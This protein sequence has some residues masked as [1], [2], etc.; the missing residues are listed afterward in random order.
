[1]SER[2]PGGIVRSTPVTPTGPL[3]NGT[4]PGVWSLADAAYWTKQ[5]LWPIAGN[6]PPAIEDYFS[7]YLYTGNGASHN[8]TNTIV[9]GIDLAG[10]GGLVWI[11]SRTDTAFNNLFDT[12][13][14]VTSQ[15]RISTNSTGAA[16]N[17][18]VFDAFN[19]DGFTVNF[20]AFASSSFDT[21]RSG[22]NYASWTFREAPNFFDI[23]TYTGDGTTGRAIS[24]NLGSA[25]GM[26]VIKAVSSTSNWFVYHRS[27]PD[28]GFLNLTEG[29]NASQRIT[30]VTSSS[31]TVS[32]SDGGYGAT[33]VNGVQ[34]VAYLYAH[35]AASDGLIQCGGYTTAGNGT[36]SVT[37]GWEPQAILLKRTDSSTNGDWILVDNM[38]GLGAFNAMGQYVLFP[39]LSSAEGGIQGSLTANATGFNFSYGGNVAA[40]Y[41]YMAIRRGPMRTPTLGTSV[42]APFATSLAV[43][44]AIT[45]NFPVDLMISGQRNS[46]NATDNW[47]FIDRLR[48]ATASD[49]TSS[50]PQKRLRSTSTSAENNPA[51]PYAY[52]WWNTGLVQ[53]Y[54]LA[55]ASQIYYT[56]RRAPGF[57]DVVCY[58]GTGTPGGG[59]T[60]AIN[61]NLGVAP[62]L[63]IVKNRSGAFGW[64]CYYPASNIGL[65]LNGANAAF[66][67]D[68][69]GVSATTFTVIEFNSTNASGSTYVAYLFASVPGVS[70]VGSY[71][72][73]GSSQ[74]INCAFT[75]GSRFVMIKRTDSTG[76]WYVWDSAR[77][78]VAG[79]DPYL[80]LNDISAEV[81]TNDSVDTASTGFIVNQVAASNV[82]VNGATY[83]FLAI[84]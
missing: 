65:L 74:T 12:D 69:T 73:N 71:T 68:F 42:F 80:A 38:R 81:T 26:I 24:H 76:D 7:T 39:N 82:N 20:S 61:H 5:G 17:N 77:G 4:A 32:S 31:F 70:K 16:Q 34:Y 75:T 41:I 53:G 72:G 51:N 48:G 59:G 57:M 2:W 18:N 45:T 60:R 9:N 15:E 43:D 22:Q 40:T 27:T 21:N 29:F 58:T 84:A 49:N 19:S 33:N 52:N 23:V 28:M 64:S 63:V 11:K 44:T 37:L 35:D 54:G 66:T 30:S 13:R 56:L 1:M 6:T 62:E 46:N 47:A 10:N 14:G 83:I 8:T 55:G 25:P 50:T 78:I 79:N 67:P 36:A 3:Q